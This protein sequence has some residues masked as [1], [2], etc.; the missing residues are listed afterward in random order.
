MMAQDKF[1]STD[2][3]RAAAERVNKGRK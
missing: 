2:K 1:L 3:V